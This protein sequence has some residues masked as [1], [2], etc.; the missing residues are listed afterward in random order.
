M[1]WVAVDTQWVVEKALMASLVLPLNLQ[2]NDH[3]FVAD[4]KGIRKA[5]KDQA[6]SILVVGDSGGLRRSSN[7]I[8][9]DGLFS[10]KNKLLFS[11]DFVD[12][13]PN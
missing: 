4:L 8:I 3:L 2:G 11:L 7:C 1:V 13:R 5:A 10:L 6:K 9:F 12:L